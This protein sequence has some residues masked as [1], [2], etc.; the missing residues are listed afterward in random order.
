MVSFSGKKAYLIPEVKLFLGYNNYME[1]IKLMLKKR[2]IEIYL[3]SSWCIISPIVIIVVIVLLNINS[4]VPIV[5]GNPLPQWSV[6]IGWLIFFVTLI[7]I[8]AC[9]INEIYKAFKNC[10][11]LKVNLLYLKKYQVSY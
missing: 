10:L 6:V 2:V 9:A 1:D 4:D 7:P 5:N 3:F 8:P 11:L